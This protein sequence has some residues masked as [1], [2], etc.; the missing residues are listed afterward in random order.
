MVHDFTDAHARVFNKHK[1][2]SEDDDEHRAH[3]P[4][5]TLETVVVKRHAAGL[6]LVLRH[7]VLDV[8]L[9][10]RLDFLAVETLD[11]IDGIDDILD[12]LALGFQMAA[13]LAPPALEPT[14]LPVGDPK[15]DGHNAKGHQP[16]IHIGDE[17]QNQGQQ[18]AGEQWQQIDEEVLH[19][20]R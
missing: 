16:Y 9:F 13:H 8:K 5:K 20:A 4:Y 15:I 7:L 10:L 19:R 14:C 17:H 6:H 3:L 11:D 1:V 12:S 2:G 18:C